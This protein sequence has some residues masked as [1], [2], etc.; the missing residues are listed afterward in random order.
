L[1]TY[2]QPRLRLTRPYDHK[3]ERTSSDWEYFAVYKAAKALQWLAEKA[4]WTD[5]ARAARGIAAFALSQLRD[6]RRKP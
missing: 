5:Q 6:L 4:G 1:S 3:A 2:R